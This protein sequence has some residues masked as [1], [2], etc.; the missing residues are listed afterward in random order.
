MSLKLSNTFHE[1]GRNLSWDKGLTQVWEPQR[2]LTLT[3]AVDASGQ[4]RRRC[5]LLTLN[6]K[7]SV[8]RGSFF[9]SYGAR[10]R[11]CR[12]SY[13][14]R[15][16][17]GSTGLGNL[18]RGPLAEV[19][20]LAIPYRDASGFEL[21]SGTGVT[22]GARSGLMMIRR[23]REISRLRIVDRRLNNPWLYETR[24]AEVRR[25]I[26]GLPDKQRAAVY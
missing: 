13:R 3:R 14:R 9:V 21:D 15:C 16:F 12:R 24:L 26:A 10:L 22:S 6:R 1:A 17:C 11:S 4:E 18:Y 19:Y 23:V 20:Y 8:S 25:A 7:A 2:L 5:K